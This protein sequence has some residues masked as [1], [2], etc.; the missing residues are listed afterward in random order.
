MIK[1]Y[2]KFTIHLNKAMWGVMAR[3][4]DWKFREAEG[5]YLKSSVTLYNLGYFLKV[6][7]KIHVGFNA[8]S[9]FNARYSS[10]I[11]NLW[12]SSTD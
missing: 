2:L 10:V 12:M 3:K 6:T 4:R 8:H 5:H 11:N 1:T 9:A 7:I